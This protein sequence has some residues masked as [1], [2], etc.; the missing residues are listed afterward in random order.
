MAF[1]EGMLIGFFSALIAVVVLYGLAHWLQLA[2]WPKSKLKRQLYQ[3]GETVTPK[4]R[5]YL[6]RTFIWLTYFAIVH[7][8]GFMVITLLEFPKTADIFYPII[9]LAIAFFAIW[10]LARVPNTT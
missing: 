4:K 10:A 8:I 1:P 2:K 3:S 6:E 5:R 7:V 9:Y